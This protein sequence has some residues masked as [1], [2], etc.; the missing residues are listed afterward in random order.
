MTD[1]VTFSTDPLEGHDLAQAAARRDCG[2]VVVFEGRVRDHHQGKAVKRLEYEAYAPMARAEIERIVAE[3]RQ[4]W[5]LGPVRVSHR[6]GELRIGDIAVVV[7]VASAHRGEA[8]EAAMFIMDELKRRAPIWKKE[9][10]QDG[11]CD[12]VFCREHAGPGH[13]H[14]QTHHAHHGEHGHV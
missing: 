3:A 6:H 14:E 8:F 12:W 2:A 1:L 10:Y 7:A 4:R 9:Y 5:P 13:V 11:T